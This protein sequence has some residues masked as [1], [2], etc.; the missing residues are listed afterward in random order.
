M[1]R[2]LLNNEHD[3]FLDAATTIT[4]VYSSSIF[5]FEEIPGNYSFPFTIPSIPENHKII[6]ALH[7][8]SAEGNAPPSFNV[9]GFFN[10]VKLFEG[11]LTIDGDIYTDKYEGTILIGTGEFAYLSKDKLLTDV[12]YGE[13]ITICGPA[14]DI[15]DALLEV[16]KKSYPDEKYSVFPIYNSDIAKGVFTVE[17]T[18]G[19]VKLFSNVSPFVNDFRLKFGEGDTYGCFNFNDYVTGNIVF[20]PFPYLCFVI[21]K[22]FK[23]FGF[24]ITD[25]I[26]FTDEELKSLVVYNIFAENTLGNVGSFDPQILIANKI[27]KIKN[28]VPKIKISEFILA[29]KNTFNLT[30]DFNYITHEVRI[31]KN[32]NIISSEPE[33]IS[34]KD[35]SDNNFSNLAQIDQFKVSAKNESND[36]ELLTFGNFINITIA[37]QVF[38]KSDLVALQKVANQVR[39]VYYEDSYYICLYKQDQTV[40]TPDLEWKI[41]NSFYRDFIQNITSDQKNIIDIQN[42]IGTL[43]TA[44]RQ[45]TDQYK[46]IQYFLRLPSAKQSGQYASFLPQ[47]MDP[48]CGLRLLFYRGFQ[49]KPYS[50][51]SWNY[52]NKLY[53][54]AS[55]DD[56]Y[57]QYLD[58]P[59]ERYNYSLQFDGTNGIISKFWKSTIYWMIHERKK[60]TFNQLISPS[61]LANLDFTKKKN[62]NGI[63]H[64]LNSVTVNISNNGIEMA[65]VEAYTV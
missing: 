25:N 8:L 41:Y 62:I 54:F 44:E 34:N 24:T 35:V 33:K 9:Q 19:Q 5:N 49:E 52:Y 45:Y 15:N 13:D 16:A 65:L 46:G 23:T 48:D 10:G 26:F 36:S 61:E 53:P 31:F 32:D 40:S 2:L 3:L 59:S 27:F 58:T 43:L 22:V 55:S 39:F 12:D 21:E 18:E 64:L 60:N 28:H 4:L 37:S 1:L 6:G 50:H 57:Y 17:D 56:N 38:Y 20:T 14:D 7:K 29:L 11:T 63:N 42:A 47:F 30:I 51:P